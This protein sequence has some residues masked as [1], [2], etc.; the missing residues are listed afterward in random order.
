MR[1]IFIL[2]TVAIIET[3]MIIALILYPRHIIVSVNTKAQT[4]TDP[5][6]WAL[7]YEA[8]DSEFEKL[9]KQYP[10]WISYRAP[11]TGWSILPESIALR[12][13]NVVRILIANGANV[14]E[15]VKANPQLDRGEV[16][17]LHKIQKEITNESAQPIH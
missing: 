16:D 2:M 12:R 1:I 17:L 10:G 6:Y 4:M 15:T 7:K 14:E 13:T 5:F 9:A 11:A 8:P 3:T